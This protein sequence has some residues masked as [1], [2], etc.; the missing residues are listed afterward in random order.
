MAVRI[1][2]YGQSAL[3]DFLPEK[4]VWIGVADAVGEFPFTPPD[5]V[6]V[7]FQ[8]SSCLTGGSQD[9]FCRFFAVFIPGQ[10]VDEDHIRM[11]QDGKQAGSQSLV[12]GKGV[13]DYQRGIRAF[14]AAERI[15]ELPEVSVK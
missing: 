3:G 12:Y 2:E 9:E 11:G 14:R 10:V 6:C 7:Q 1:D 4:R 8:N 15:D 5:A 13:F